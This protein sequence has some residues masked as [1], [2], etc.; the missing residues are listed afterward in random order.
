[1]TTR[2]DP[3][4][5][6]ASWLE[7]GPDVLPESTR[8]AIQVTTRTTHQ[9]RRLSWL[10]WRAIHMNGTTRVALAV[11][12]VVAVAVGG[13]YFLRPATDPS[14]GIGGPGSPVPSASPAAST[15]ASPGASI[16]EMTE[17]FTSAKFGYSIHYPADW[18]VTPAKA[19]TTGE[20]D[21]FDPPGGVGRF[22]ALSVVVPAGV[23]VDDWITQNI[24]ASDI[25]ECAPP[26][27]TLAE[28]TIDGQ[29][30]R[31]RGFCGNPPATE[32]EATVVVDNRVY[33]FTLFRGNEGTASEGE[34]R[35]LFDAFTATVTLNP[36]DAE[37]SPG[38]GSS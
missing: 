35:S 12:A 14:S 28:V 10:P 22:R 33:V 27:D 13:M 37:G 9:A 3:D 7:E 29:P 21:T 2:H 26:R 32:I 34:L 18:T 31:F 11:A 36:Q 1:M 20:S 17:T 38:P 8:R 16:P 5:I 15:P 25:P 4:A 30:G 6:L 23:V 19:G 24:T